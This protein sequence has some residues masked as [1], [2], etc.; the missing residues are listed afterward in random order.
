MM[1]SGNGP[2]PNKKKKNGGGGR[3]AETLVPLET[4]CWK[5]QRVTRLSL[6]QAFP[7]GSRKREKEGWG[8]GGGQW[9]EASLVV[10]FLFHTQSNTHLKHAAAISQNLSQPLAFSCVWG[11]FVAGL[12]CISRTGGIKWH[13]ERLWAQ[14]FSCSGTTHPFPVHRTR[15]SV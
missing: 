14:K 3:S 10:P 2:F 6:L 15:R 11:S 4:I 7:A 9:L 1:P 5:S 8:G 12:D 13:C